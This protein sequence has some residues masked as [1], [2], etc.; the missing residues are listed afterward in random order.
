MDDKTKK[1]KLKEILKA[2]GVT[3]AGAAIGGAVMAPKDTLRALSELSSWDSPLDN[4]TLHKFYGDG[5]LFEKIEENPNLGIGINAAASGLGALAAYGVLKGVKKAI[6]NRDE[7]KLEL[8]RAYGEAV[9]NG[10]A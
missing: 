3:G 4:Y 8:A 5:G 7:K 10:L 2:A 9:K 1:S 6:H